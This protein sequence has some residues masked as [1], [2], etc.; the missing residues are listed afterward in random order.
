MVESTTVTFLDGENVRPQKINVSIYQNFVWL[1][2]L[3][4]GASI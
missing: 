1:G 2:L 3:L 4:K